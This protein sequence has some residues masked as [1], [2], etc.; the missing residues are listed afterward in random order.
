M[1]ERTLTAR[2]KS[3]ADQALAGGAYPP[4]DS[5]D[6]ETHPGNDLRR[7]DLILRAG[8]VAVLTAEFKLPTD[9]H[10][11]SPFDL[12]VVRA[13]REK[14]VAEG[15]DY[16]GTCNCSSFVLW[17]TNV[18]GLPLQRSY[19]RR[20]RVVSPEQLTALD[21][22][23]ATGEFRAFVPVLLSEL[24]SLL[25]GTSRADVSMEEEQLVELIEDRLW[26][27]VGLSLPAV[28]HAFSTDAPF[29]RRMKDWMLTDQGWTWD[30][31]QA[32]DLLFQ[33][34]QVGCYLLMNQ[35]LFYEAMRRVFVELQPLNVEAAASGEGLAARLK[36]RFD[37]AMATSRDYESVFDVGFITDVAFKSNAPVH[38]WQ[39]LIGGVQDV[40]LARYSTDLLGG[41]F[42]RLLSPEERHRFGQHYT[43][44]ELADVL[45]AAT[46]S[47]RTDAIFDPAAGGGTFLVRAYDRLRALGEQDHLVLLSRIY[48]NDVS[49]FATHLS[50]I[51][52]AVRSLAR[53]E[54]Y[55]R[56]GTHDF[57]RLRP[58]APLVRLPL[59]GGDQRV[60]HSPESVDVMI[61]N[62]PYIKRR[63]MSRDQLRS[64]EASLV[65]N[66]IRPTLHGLSDL[67][68]YFW[69]QAARY[70]APGGRLAFL[71]SSS[72]LDSTSGTS[73]K[74]FLKAN[75]RIR[76]IVES[77]AEPWFSDARV[78]TIATVLVRE[79]NAESRD[80][81]E[82]TFAR[83]HRPLAALL[84]PRQGFSSLV[85]AVDRP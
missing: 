45:L 77:E 34:T 55:P 61:G 23:V 42:E 29:R 27:I 68:A 76:A 4:I 72:W 59:H 21:G 33:A 60:V 65:L 52:L 47:L 80:G 32:R 31:T 74:T 39:G 3:W 48:G 57:L 73:L 37:E 38:A 22:P 79:P 82:V 44:P 62:P 12:A 20:W 84:G 16:F 1:D 50:T 66:P 19:V 14:A 49:R 54:N 36:P 25:A 40:D 13:A 6:T 43:S 7:H 28:E 81:N 2:F 70:L 46:V 8:G 10:G 9:A 71:T 75:F 67:H 85:I 63:S 17:R 35:I 83:M 64:A 58:G 24:T 15:V 18:P 5:A 41:V 53:E 56:V 51:N 11:A 26:V 30:D 69:P 78:R